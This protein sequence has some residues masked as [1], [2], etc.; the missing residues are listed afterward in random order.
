MS[1][2][3]TDR[4]HTFPAE[5]TFRRRYRLRTRTAFTYDWI[6]LSRDGSENA[7]LATEH[8]ID[9]ADRHDAGLH[10]LYVAEKTRDDPTQQ[11]LE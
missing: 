9:M 4:C 5:A 7:T 3:R 11:G 10:A 2:D 1:C 8:A 6:L